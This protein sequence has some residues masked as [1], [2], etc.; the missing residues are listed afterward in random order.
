MVYGLY[1][2]SPGTGFLAPV[3]AMLVM[4]IA[5]LVSAP[6]DQDHTISPSALT[7]SSACKLHA[8]NDRVHRIPHPTLV[9][10]A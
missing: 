7:R 9:T 5:S 6:G 4:N 3:A 2:L 10:I 1:V 8:A